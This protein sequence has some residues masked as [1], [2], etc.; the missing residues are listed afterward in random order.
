MIFGE[1]GGVGLDNPFKLSE[2]PHLQFS[3]SM[4][5]HALLV[6]LSFSFHHNLSLH[7]HPFCLS[8]SNPVRIGSRQWR[9]FHLD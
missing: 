5:H 6:S 2:R 9:S 3:F 4:L 8:V 7:P 1:G